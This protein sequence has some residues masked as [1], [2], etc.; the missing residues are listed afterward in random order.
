MNDDYSVYE[1]LMYK[2]KR[3]GL[4]KNNITRAIDTVRDIP[5]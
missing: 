3:E 4:G 5:F 2:W 1:D